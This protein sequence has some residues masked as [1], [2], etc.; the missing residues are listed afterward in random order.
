VETLIQQARDFYEGLEPKQQKMLIGSVVACFVMIVCVGLWANGESWREVVH[1]S[2]DEVSRGAAALSQDGIAHRISENGMVLSVPDHEMGRAHLAVANADVVPTFELGVDIPAHLT[3]RQQ[4]YFL[5]KMEETTLA[6]MIYQLE[7]VEYAWVTINEGNE[8]PYIGREKEASASVMLRVRDGSGLTDR[9][10]RSIVNL[11]AMSVDELD[12]GRVSVADQDGNVLHSPDADGLAGDGDALH[13][14][15]VRQQKN[16]ESNVSEALKPLLGG[17]NAVSVKAIVSLDHREE[18]RMDEAYDLDQAFART[19]QI[20]DRLSTEGEARGAA[21]TASNGADSMVGED[22][23]SVTEETRSST[24]TSAPKSV[25]LV[26]VRPGDIERI[27]VTVLVDERVISDIATARAGEEAEESALAEARAE[28]QSQIRTASTAAAG[29][30]SARGDV[31]EVVFLPFQ[32]LPVTTEAPATIGVVSLPWLPYAVA[33]L[34]LI[35]TFAFVVRPLIRA[36]TR[37]PELAPGTVIGPN[38][39]VVTTPEA[40]EEDE[41]DDLAARL[42]LLVENYESV[43]ADDLNRLVDR[44]AE[45]AAQVLR[46]WSAKG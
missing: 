14:L 11:V 1:G 23:G 18:Q 42:R 31:V 30:D 40:E 12:P 13:Q 24:E 4:A 25:A 38:G 45:A 36:V 32:E 17:R 43:D 26:K 7:P 10:V 41:D 34:A 29:F 15:Q 9:Q 16:I 39:E 37:P 3:P 5:N 35:L 44:E 46:T 19:E 22:G 27:S 21:G 6:H 2:P 20:S 33:A 8:L 28:V